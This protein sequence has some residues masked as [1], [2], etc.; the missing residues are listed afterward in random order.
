MKGWL[1]FDGL[2]HDQNETFGRINLAAICMDTWPKTISVKGRGSLNTNIGDATN[3]HEDSMHQ[4]SIMIG[5]PTG[6][7]YLLGNALYVADIRD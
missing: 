5:T 2:F 6:A 1:A 4:D 3:T 7:I